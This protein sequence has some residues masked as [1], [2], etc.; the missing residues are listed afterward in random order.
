MADIIN[1]IT[2]ELSKTQLDISNQKR[3]LATFSDYL[4]KE[5]KEIKWQDF[6]PLPNHISYEG[7]AKPNPKEISD[8]LD[9]V[10]ICKVNGGLG[11]SMNCKEAKSSIIA[12]NGKSFL[13][14]TCRQHIYLQEKW[15]VSISFLLMNSFYTEKITLEKIKP[16]EKYI[17]FICFLQSCYPRL[18]V[19]KENY[20]IL[21]SKE[22]KKAAFYP[23]GHGDIYAQL[24]GGLLD[25]LLAKN[26]RYLFL[27]NIDN[28]S[29]TIDFL[30]LNYLKKT[31]CPF[32]METVSKSAADIKGGSLIRHK[33]TKKIKLLESA[34]I[35]K[36]NSLHWDNIKDKLSSFNTNNI[37]FDLI[38]LKEKLTKKDWQ[39][40]LIT[41]Y[42]EIEQKKILQLETVMG[43]AIS[44]FNKAQIMK[45]PRSR[46]FPVK[47]REDLDKLQSKDFVLDEE[48]GYI[49]RKNY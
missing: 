44:N 43:S 17:D 30:I 31:N 19:K 24:K 47:T 35:P 29:A 23:P 4:E 9:K 38:Q 15:G 8:L 3:F 22:F 34:E 14:I 5:R 12:K 39:L 6:E 27:S 10:V 1:S 46:F 28:L 33:N 11:T 20:Q 21:N 41:N 2:A 48:N 40:D 36:S 45:V 18:E 32:L 13:D 26:K 25:K 42:K 49:L 16:Y 7:I 37:W